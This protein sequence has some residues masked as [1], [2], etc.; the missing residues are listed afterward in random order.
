[1]EGMFKDAYL[2]IY[3]KVDRT[4]HNVSMTVAIDNRLLTELGLGDV[5][6]A[7]AVHSDSAMQHQLGQ[8]IQHDTAEMKSRELTPGSPSAHRKPA[9]VTVGSPQSTLQQS[10]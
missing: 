4:E 7:E 2:L 9:A 10:G 8:P 3:S 1:M 6:Q 5:R